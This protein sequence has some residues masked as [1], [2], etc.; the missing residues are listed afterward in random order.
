MAANLR[1]ALSKA[2]LAIL[3]CGAVIRNKLS[4]SLKP[5]HYLV[6]D[7]DSNVQRSWT[8]LAGESPVAVTIKTA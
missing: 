1:E 6:R 5:S 2:D 8:N 4:L 7:R 3:A